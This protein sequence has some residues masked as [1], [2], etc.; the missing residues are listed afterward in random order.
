MNET[1][2]MIF[3]HRV[4]ECFQGT[5]DLTPYLCVE[6]ALDFYQEIGGAPAIARHAEE[7]LDFGEK[8]FKD[9][10]DVASAP[11]PKSMRAPY[12][13]IIGELQG[14]PTSLDNFK[15]QKCLRAKRAPFTKKCI[16]VNFF[17]N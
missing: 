13:R 6:E 10:F 5:R 16:L 4:N 1:F 7:L 17:R 8:L 12:M 15:A 2:S 11:F 9:Y 3:K 14:V